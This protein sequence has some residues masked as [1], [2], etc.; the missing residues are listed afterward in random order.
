MMISREKFAQIN[1]W[2]V[3]LIL[4]T[5]FFRSLASILIILFAV[6]NLA[7]YKYLSFTKKNIPL[8]FVICIPFL[9]EIFFL[10]NNLDSSRAFKPIEKVL[11]FLIFPLF[12][13]QNYKIYDFYKIVNIYRKIFTI[14]LLVLMLRFLYF[15]PEYVHKYLNGID[16][17]E[18]GYVFTQSF[19]NHAPVVNMHIAFVVI[20]NLFFIFKSEDLKN[21]IVNYIFLII[22]IVALFFVNTRLSLGSVIICSFI[23]FIVLI[24]KKYKLKGFYMLGGFILLV[25]TIVFI[26]FKTNPYMKE[27]Y[28]KVTFAYMDKIGKLDEVENPDLVLHNALV[29]RVSIWKSALDVGKKEFLFGYGSAH[30]KD[31]LNKY[32]TDSNQKFLAKYD[33]PVHNQ[34]LDYF[35][36]YGIVGVLCLFILFISVFRI[37]ILSKNILGLCFTL[38]FLFSNLFDDFLIR[39]DGIVYSSIFFSLICVYYLKFKNGHKL[40][41]FN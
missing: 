10:W 15:F 28:S 30:G 32:Y 3:I 14:M 24:Y 9:I 37:S 36:K 17:W 41:N 23:M 21:K 39:F 25:F 22:I 40:F 31:V 35:L 33:F 13:I 5:I 8:L 4:S 2:F 29:T 6:F 18:M 20:L 27:K 1:N 12:I 16:L 34:F 7:N 11:S 19:G 26:A 38:N